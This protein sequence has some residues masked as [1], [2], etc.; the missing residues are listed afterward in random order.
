MLLAVVLIPFNLLVALWGWL[1][2]FT[3]RYSGKPLASGRDARAKQADLRQMILWGNALQAQQRVLDEVQAEQ[4]K[5]VRAPAEWHLLRQSREGVSE[6]LAEAVATFDL[7]P[8]GDVLYSDGQEIWLR[9]RSG[10]RK[11]LAKDVGVQ[12]VVW[13]G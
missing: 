12:Q 7:T 2:M 11:C 5:D 9:R 13:L 8:E 6:R 1:N 3:M 10:E 4:L